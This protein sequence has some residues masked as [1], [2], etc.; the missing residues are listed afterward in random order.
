M[1]TISLGGLRVSVIGL[2]CWTFGRQLAFA[3][4]ERVVHAALDAGI[5]FFDTADRYGKGTAEQFRPGAGSDLGKGKA[6]E[7]LGHALRNRRRHVIVATKFGAGLGTGHRSPTGQRYNAGSGRRAYVEAC[8]EGSL[9]R[10]GTDDIDL[11][12][13][14]GPDLGTP[15]DRTHDG[16]DRLVPAGTGPPS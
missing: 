8:I 4:V 10:L 3:E 11:F 2:G 16:P 7:F 14:H 6:E 12:P 5:T 1:R 15:I 13:M 9:R